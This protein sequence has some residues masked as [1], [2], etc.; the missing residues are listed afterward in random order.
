MT[1]LNSHVAP[2]GGSRLLPVAIPRNRWSLLAS[3]L[4][5]IG[6][7]PGLN[8]ATANPQPVPL[9]E[10]AVAVPITLTGTGTGTL[11]YTVLTQPTKGVLTGTGANLFYQPNTNANGSDSFTFKVTDTVGDSTAAAVSISITAVND[12]PVA[13]IPVVETLAGVN[14]TPRNTS[15]SLKWQAIAASADGEKLAAVVDGGQIYTSSNSGLNWSAVATDLNWQSIASSADGSKLVAVVDVGNIYTSTDS[16]ANWTAR[17]TVRNWRSVASS[18]D[19]QKLVAIE[20]S[21]RIYTSVDGGTTW[22]SRDSDRPWYAVASSSSGSNLVAAVYGGGLYTSTNVGTNWVQRTT[23]DKLWVSVASSA[24]GLKLVAAE[25]NGFIHTSADGGANWIQQAGSGAKFW[26]SV[27]SSADGVELIA[28][29]LGGKLYTSADSGATWVARDSDRLWWATAASAS[30][31]DLFAV[32]DGGLIYT[33]ED[34]NVP[35]VITVA[36]DSGSYTNAAFFTT[37]SAGPADESSQVLTFSVTTDNSAL[38]GVQPAISATGVLT[39]TP[40][41]NAN[42]SATIT[43]VSVTDNGGTANSGQNSTVP[44]PRNQVLVTVSPVNDNPT[45]GA[46]AI[47]GTEDTT[48]N[49][50][51]AAFS[52]SYNVAHPDSPVRPAVGYT[53]ES[54]PS[55]GTLKFG[56]AAVAVNQVISVANL[57]GLTYE[58]VLNESGAKTFRVSVSDGNLSSPKGTNGALVTMTLAPVNDAP[59]A[60]AQSVTTLE[61]NAVTISLFGT[62]PD[63]DA[64][65]ASLVSGP[66]NGRYVGSVYTPTTNFSGID[67]ITF[68]VSDGTLPSSIEKVSIFVVGVND[69]PVMGAV[70]VAGAEDTLVSFSSV[71][72]ASQYSDIESDPFTSLTVTTLP[73]TGSLKLAGSAVTAGQVIPV[74]E[75]GGL[76]YMPA[77]NETGAKTFTVRA[78]DGS[79]LSVP[80][81]VIIVLGGVND[82]PALAAVSKSL[83]E[84]ATLTFAVSDFYNSVTPATSKFSDPEGSGLSSV[85]VLS[86]PT[87]GLLKNTGTNVVAGLVVTAG[88]IGQLTYARAANEN[89]DA[90]FTVSASDGDLS[91]EAA[92]VTLSVVAVNDAPSATIPTVT[93]V[94]VG[95]TLNVSLAGPLNFKSVAASADASKLAAV[96]DNGQIQVSSDSG[97]T[98]TARESVRNWSSVA[99]STNGQ[100]LAASVFRGKIYV[101]TNAGS[102]WDARD[103][104]RT[105]RSVAISTNGAVMAA[106]ANGAQVYVSVDSG[107]NW[108]A[109]ATSQLWTSVAMSADGSKMVASV[110]GGSLYTSVDK[111]TNWTAVA[112]PR[113]WNS[114]ASSPDGV[115]LVATEVQGSIWMS[116]DSGA[117]WVAN[118]AAGSRNW[119]TVAMSVDGSRLLA[120]VSGGK[121]YRSLDGGVSWQEAKNSSN[122]AWSGIAGSLDLKKAIVAVDGGSLSTTV[123]YNIPLTITVAEDSGTYTQAGFATGASAGPSNESSQTLSY[124]V[125]LS[126]V[127]FT[128]GTNLFVGVPTVDASGALSFVPAPDATGSA[129][130]TVSVKDNGGVT[131]ILNTVTGKD[132]AVVGS[133]TVVVSPVDDA[134]TAIAQTVGV[135]EETAKSITLAGTDPENVALTYELLTQP[136]KGVLSGTAPSL[137]Y[138]PTLNLTG[139]DSFTFRV[140]DASL[141]SSVATVSIVITNVND[142][143]VANAQSVT[144]DE[145]TAKTITLVGTDVEG[146][147]LTYTVLTQPTKGALSGTAPVLTYT[148]TANYSGPDSFTFKV[149]DG[150]VDSLVA[151]VSITVT[152]VIDIPVA[153]NAVVGILEDNGAVAFTLTGSSPEGRAITFQVLTSPIKGNLDGAPPNLTYT[154]STNQAGTD[155]FTFKVND[156]L[157]NS[158]VATVTLNITNVNDLPSFTIPTVVKPGGEIA[159]WTKLRDGNASWNIRDEQRRQSLAISTNGNVVVSATAT[160][161]TVS[162]DGGT[163]ATNAITLGSGGYD[164]IAIS[165]NGSKIF[166]ARGTQLYAYNGISWGAAL[167]IPALDWASL[168]SSANGTNLVAVAAG[169][170]MQVSTNS[171]TTWTS[172]GEARDWEAVTSSADG[173]KLAGAVYNGLI[174]TTTDGGTNWTTRGSVNRY[175]TSIASSA[176]GTKLAATEVNGLIYTSDDSGATWTARESARAWSS[177]S[178]SADGKLLLAG[179]LGGKLYY[180]DDSGV[181]WSAKDEVRVWGSVAIAGDGGNAVAAVLDGGLYRAAGYVSE[182]TVSAVEDT[183]TTVAG[184]ATEISAGPASESSQVVS[185]VLSS[186]NANLF[187][188]GPAISTAGELTFTPAA[189]AVGTALVEVYAQ[190]NGGTNY[191]GV[192]RSAVKRFKIT[193]T[194]ENDAPVAGSQAV[195][196]VEDTAKAITL[197]AYDAEA[198][199]LTYTVVRPPTKGTLSGTAPN[200]VYTPSTNANGADN[201]TYKVSDGTLESGVAT[202]TIVVS[203][204]NDLPVVSGQSVTTDEDAPVAITLSGSDVDGDTLTYTVVAGPTK[205]E[206]TGTAPNLVYVPNSD[207]SGTDS[208]TYKV[209]DGTADSGLATVSITVASVNDAPVAGTQS[210]K[211]D[212]DTAA[213]ITLTGFDPEGATLTYKV[214]SQPA[215]GV[216]S[217]EG[218]SLEYMPNPD[219]NGK[220]SFTY[221]VSD[222]A[223]DSSAVTVAITV[224]SIPD[225][226]V[227]LT[228]TVKAVQGNSAAVTLK[229]YD[230]DNDTLTYT[231]ASQPTKGTLS[232]TAPN[233]VY[234]ANANATGTD[235]I[236]FRAND[237]TSD[238]GLAT[239]LI[240]IGEASKLSIKASSAET[241]TLEVRAP[242]GAVVQIENATKLGAWSATAI[243]VTGEGTDVGVPV[244]LQVDKNVPARFWRLNILSMP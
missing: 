35:A 167:N 205:G 202:V 102:T 231:L 176:D 181:S 1:P 49:F 124:T 104:D 37:L 156:G 214:V 224:A 84:D 13:I 58:P 68:R 234:T 88:Q 175:W 48:V 43:V 94:P 62:D 80:T 2:V 25:V 240:V 190:D 160:A 195:A 87:A 83:N 55:S 233:L 114:V 196:A 127:T 220:D 244:N 133:F 98:W 22:A 243:K 24:N 93:L 101:S 100:V 45:Q 145:D 5:A 97:A 210:V 31:G 227:A 169:D 165:A 193:V 50:T 185:F 105:W 18:A 199:A 69:A 28:S 53:I 229:A 23:G 30:G 74:A 107:T 206:L 159:T 91:S 112:S 203:A 117:T 132:T 121:L 9:L 70:T 230:G 237:G 191:A 122:S 168:A 15:G 242:K 76:T 26:T 232:G 75:L 125:A 164:A 19:G 137:I 109:R 73:A 20:Y 36:E 135:V 29:T 223:L 139:A 120:G 212:E 147:A 44:I 186:N 56:G 99:S 215:N 161:L 171:G 149:N 219:F 95:D 90:T 72:F 64:L 59:F 182:Y 138:T 126:G 4:L 86:L 54:L 204:V 39:F 10:D 155:S 151:L 60:V 213:M 188:E 16:G 108:T 150:T 34:T 6:G 113:L 239:V 131:N 85:K 42:G 225:G 14:W 217:G 136:T 7:L 11:T 143:A 200:L 221:K 119:S 63:G 92:V 235:S 152:P 146:S 187:S 236:T 38:F 47:S 192:D 116:A 111:G 21:G 216:V 163:T 148:P 238:S 142:V 180:S 174:Y 81:T 197:G 128:G 78:S 179:V 207:V 89:G 173:M 154:P 166:V 27:A 222:G 41:T 8:A 51:A 52:A 178:M 33:S 189:D 157:N 12:A 123:D 226:P 153:S 71:L 130:L 241:L 66:T 65:T 103:S 158:A 3:A 228:Q 46:I 40:A 162:T 17:E 177:I 106:V 82:A 140:K 67:T 96:V 129:T 194:G 198:S 211:T 172:V 183:M 184:F 208:F 79:A 77:L 141:T 134:P 32:T 218:A 110:Y 144:T 61:D 170:K 118:T 201:F 57:V 209:N 115:K